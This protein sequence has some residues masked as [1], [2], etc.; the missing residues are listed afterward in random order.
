MQV[1]GEVD[2]VA[3]AAPPQPGVHHAGGRGDHRVGLDARV[4]DDVDVVLVVVRAVGRVGPAEPP[5][6]H[7][8]VLAGVGELDADVVRQ[9]RE[10]APLGQPAEHHVEHLLDAVGRQ[11]GVEL[12]IVPDRRQL[13]VEPVDQRLVRLSPQDEADGLFLRPGPGRV[14]GIGVAQCGDQPGR[15]LV[16]GGEQRRRTTSAT[17][18]LSGR[19]SGFLGRLATTQAQWAC[20][21]ARWSQQVEGRPGRAASARG[22][23]GPRRPAPRGSGPTRTRWRT[24]TGKR[25]TGSWNDG[26]PRDRHRH[27]ARPDVHDYAVICIVMQHDAGRGSRSPEPVGTPVA[28]CCACS[29]ATRGR[30]RRPHRRRPTRGSRWASCSRT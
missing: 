12:G 25:S 10:L 2:R 27:G 29:W 23:R 22:R 9:R 4:G 7:P 14:G 16:E 26:S 20:V 13:G 8:H 1:A 24:G 18:R 3:V 30:D 28:S 19:S 6:L 15:G 11:R 5:Q 21:S 17:A